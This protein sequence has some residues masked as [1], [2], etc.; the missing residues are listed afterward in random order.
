MEQ[1]LLGSLEWHKV[2]E[3][4]NLAAINWLEKAQSQNNNMEGEALKHWCDLISADQ[5]F[6]EFGFS[7]FEYNSVNLTKSHYKGLLI[8]AD[9]NKCALANFLNERLGL[10]VQ[11]HPHWI[12]TESLSPILEFVEEN[13]SRLGVLSVDIDG[14]DYWVLEKCLSHVSPEIICVE[15]NASFGHRCISTPY[16]HDFDRHVQHSSGLYHGASCSAFVNLLKGSYSLVQNI[17]GLNLIFVRK[18]RL[19]S[20]VQTFDELNGY[21]EQ[22]LR[23]K[24]HQSNAREQWK[25]IEH[26]EF[27]EVG[28]QRK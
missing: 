6:V 21:T 14:N 10:N 25:I 19:P 23:N 8:D 16:S 22:T 27:I 12:T 13:K 9:P 7:I 4:I 15:Y 24:N 20:N 1:L 3:T 18:D 17:E 2:S 11:A 5:S 28:P 26:L